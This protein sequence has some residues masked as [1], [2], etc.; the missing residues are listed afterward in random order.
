MQRYTYIVF[1]L[2]GFTTS[3]TEPDSMSSLVV[4][5]GEAGWTFVDST[6]VAASAASIFD[7]G[8]FF[9]SLVF[10]NK[11]EYKPIIIKTMPSN[12]QS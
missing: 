2:Q 5:R 12:L 8:M 7:L 11:K 1:T 4:V 9:I 6:V 3:L 10:P